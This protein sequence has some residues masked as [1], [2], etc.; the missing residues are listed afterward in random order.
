MK[1]IA[2]TLSLFVLAACGA[3]RG[4][5][6]D[7]NPLS[8]LTLL[9]QIAQAKA[10][11]EAD[12]KAL[13]DAAPAAFDVADKNGDGRLQPRE[14]F[15]FLQEGKLE[16]RAAFVQLLRGSSARLRAAGDVESVAIADRIDAVLLEVDA[17]LVVIDLFER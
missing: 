3:L 9:G 4:A 14:M 6:A 13:R 5:Q 11:T 17:W 7:P 12:L 2:L 1:T 15:R 16:A 8:L 10:E